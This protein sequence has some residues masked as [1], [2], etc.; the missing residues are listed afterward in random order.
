MT[1][2]TL[3]LAAAGLT[4]VEIHETHRVHEHARAAIIQARKPEPTA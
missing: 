4:D 3:T 2:R 1:H